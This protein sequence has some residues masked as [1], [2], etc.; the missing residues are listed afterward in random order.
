M[1]LY[2]SYN[3]LVEENTGN[4]STIDEVT[5]VLET[6]QERLKQLEKTFKQQTSMLTSTTKQLD[7]AMLELGQSQREAA[8]AMER[9]R[10]LR[11]LLLEQEYLTK[12]R[13]Y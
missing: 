12:S 13:S 7:G 11:Q 2:E 6:N 5:K 8:E 4:K 1:Y 9:V 3:S 10:E